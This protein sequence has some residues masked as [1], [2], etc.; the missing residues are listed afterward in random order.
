MSKSSSSRRQ[1]G[2]PWHLPYFA[3]YLFAD[4]FSLSLSQFFQLSL[5]IPL[6]HTRDE[7]CL[8]CTNVIVENELLSSSPPPIV[9][10]D[11]RTRSFDKTKRT[12][13]RGPRYVREKHRRAL[14]ERAATTDRRSSVDARAHGRG[15][16]HHSAREL[17]LGRQTLAPH[18]LPTPFSTDTDVLPFHTFDFL[19]PP[20]LFLSHPSIVSPS[21][22][23]FRYPFAVERT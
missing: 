1:T 9:K 12:N 14:G 4:P 17:L 5:S 20:P 16:P 11:V 23:P 8:R 3:I 18:P 21:F 19:Q 7:R 6:D 22:Q 15:Y 2:S 13:T 10:R